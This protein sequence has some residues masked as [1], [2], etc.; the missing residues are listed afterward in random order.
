MTSPDTWT[1]V[2]TGVYLLSNATQDLEK[3][4][5]V[6]T[7]YLE[8]NRHRGLHIV[9]SKSGFGKMFAMSSRNTWKKVDTGVY[10]LSNAT[11]NLEKGSGYLHRIPGR[12]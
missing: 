1:E 2:D 12:R 3:V 4:R 7:G 10:I 6:F 8:V 9:Q 11:R 5:D